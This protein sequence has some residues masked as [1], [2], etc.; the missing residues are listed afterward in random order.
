MTTP[1]YLPVQTFKDWHRSEV[2][3]EDTIIEAAINA[4]EMAIDNA[5]QR[6]MIL[7]DPVVTSVR[8]FRPASS[9]QDVLHIDDAAAVTAISDNGTA[10]VLATDYQ[11]EPLNGL[12]DAG[13][14]WPYSTIRRR[15]SSWTHDDAVALVSVTARWGWP[16]IPAQVVE[17]CKIIAADML[18]NRDMRFGLAAIT[19]AGG[20]GTREN[21]TVRDMIRDYASYKTVALA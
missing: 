6:K 4:A 20:V 8:V 12:S 21:K 10:L 19:D 18:A 14:A 2:T 15:N 17:S 7:A 5:L 11:L 3:A 16:A 13:E 9:Y 1:R